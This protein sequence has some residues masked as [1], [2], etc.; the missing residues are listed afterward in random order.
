MFTSTYA[1]IIYL[2][3]LQVLCKLTT[4]RE[5]FLVINL[6]L[7]LKC[8]AFCNNYISMNKAYSTKFKNDHLNLYELS[9]ILK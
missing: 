1:F 5:N 4:C 3:I 2:A 8:G 7:F 9:L 6:L